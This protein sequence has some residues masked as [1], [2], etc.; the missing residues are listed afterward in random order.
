MQ[1]DDK[2][3]TSIDG[4]EIAIMS[5]GTDEDLTKDGDENGKKPV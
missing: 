2:E 5:E 4:I 3:N 1:G